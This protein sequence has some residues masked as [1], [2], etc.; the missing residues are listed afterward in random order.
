MH[1]NSPLLKPH[2]GKSGQQEK[3]RIVMRKAELCDGKNICWFVASAEVP[4]NIAHQESAM[5]RPKQSILGR[6][7]KQEHLCGYSSRSCRAFWNAPIVL[8]VQGISICLTSEPINFYLNSSVDTG[9][10]SSNCSLFTPHIFI[11]QITAQV[12]LT[13][14]PD[15]AFLKPTQSPL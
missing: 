11:W 9:F 6:L 15:V 8:P 12:A 5:F 13:T 4:V 14:F 2:L 1:D 10:A 3:A 7:R